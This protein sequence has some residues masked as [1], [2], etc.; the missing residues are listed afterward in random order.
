MPRT[1]VP[2]GEDLAFYHGYLHEIRAI[3]A[4]G[5]TLSPYW[6]GDDPAHPDDP[7]ADAITVGWDDPALHYGLSLHA[8]RRYAPTD[9]VPAPGWDDDG[10]PLPGEGRRA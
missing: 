6:G 7:C 3:D 9:Q 5:V 2:L 4:E 10:E 1:T 8:R